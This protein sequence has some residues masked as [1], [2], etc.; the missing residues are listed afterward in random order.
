MK[1][2]LQQQDS[3]AQTTMFSEVKD[4]TFFFPLISNEINNMKENVLGNKNT[5]GLF[6]N[7]LGKSC[8]LQCQNM[9]GTC[10]Y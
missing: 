8:E 7:N 10:W 3:D 1:D 2:I 9:G 6:I 4:V 5:D